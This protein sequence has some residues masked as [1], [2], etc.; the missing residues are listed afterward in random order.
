MQHKCVSSGGRGLGVCMMAGILK[1]QFNEI[2]IRKRMFKFVGN[3]RIT[4]Y[5]LDDEIGDALI[6]FC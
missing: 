6:I 5:S 1:Q 4:G 2:I 3:F